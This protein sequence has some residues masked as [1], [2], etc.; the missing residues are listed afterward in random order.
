ELLRTTL[1]GTD[2]PVGELDV[3]TSAE[4]LQL[5]AWGEGPRRALPSMTVIRNFESQV[6]RTPTHPA[7]FYGE[8]CVDYAG[9]HPRAHQLA[10][11]LQRLGVASRDRVA[12]CLPRG[13]DFVVSVLAV[14]K[15]GAAYVPLDPAYP[16]A[17]LDF[18][19][20]DCGAAVLLSLSSIAERMSA[21]TVQ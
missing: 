9:L 3:L 5:L 20:S 19:L 15:T 12:V 18:M 6:R 7:V 16:R 13:I 14:L 2:R 8:E 4:R 10:R 17:R 11:Y 21:E 1:S